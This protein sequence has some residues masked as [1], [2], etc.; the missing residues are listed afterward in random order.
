M[1]LDETESLLSV[2]VLIDQSEVVRGNYRLPG[3]V[4]VKELPTKI[5]DLV[6]RRILRKLKPIKKKISHRRYL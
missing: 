6:E 4:D 3:T 1:N 2:A 5:L